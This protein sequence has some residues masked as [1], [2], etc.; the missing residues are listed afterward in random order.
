[1][2]SFFESK[3]FRE[4]LRIV[5]AVTIGLALGFIITLFVSKDPVG[6]YKSFLLGPI[7]RL[8]RIGDWLEESLTLIL[9][10]LVIC[11]VFGASQWYIGVEGQMVLGAMAAGC[12]ALYVPVPPLPIMIP[13]LAVLMLTFTLFAALSISILDIPAAY[14]FFLIY[15]LNFESSS[16]NSLKFLSL[17]Y[18]LESQSFITP[19]LRPCG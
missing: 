6:A 10:G 17:E 9:L 11:I 16:R 19:T 4:L 1:M 5:L 2:K 13:G 12:V 3:G 14:N 8:N 15:F 7:S 18:H